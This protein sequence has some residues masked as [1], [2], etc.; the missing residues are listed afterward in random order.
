M[1]RAFKR[2]R[3]AARRRPLVLLLALV[4]L[5]LVPA[6]YMI[7]KAVRPAVEKQAAAAGK[8]IKAPW[9]QP[10][11][12]RAM[13]EASV[14]GP[15]APKALQQRLE[16]LAAHYGE[17]VGLAVADVERGWIAHVN[18]QTLLPQQSVSKTWVALATLDAVDRGRLRLDQPVV[19]GPADRSVFY[20]PIVG[21]LRK[22][23][24]RTTVGEL[25]QRAIE[26]SDN[27]AND[28]LIG[29]IGGAGE[30]GKTLA[31]KGLGGIRVG[32]AERDLQARIAGLT[33]SSDISGW[34]FK[35]ARALVP[36]EVRETAL[37]RYLADPDDGATPVGIVQG[38]MA[39]KRGELVSDDSTDLLLDLLA[40][41]KTGRRRL[42]AGLPGGWTIGDK[43]GTG[44]DWQG[45]SAGINDIG[46]ITAPDGRA[47]TVAVM[48]PN[49]KQPDSVRHRLF[50]EVAASVV[51]A[52][53]SER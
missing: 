5:P 9:P 18:G 3:R 51:Q 37:N 33:W 42:R 43:T 46:V 39:L 19:M 12:G 45:A 32:S 16:A 26:Q 20:E 13:A 31:A 15:P 38:L 40:N 21:R 49:T 14:P 44:P 27:A 47:Y 8:V 2:F 6:G 41:C 53:S 10:P 35:Q 29:L 25:L 50:R 48:I 17:P 52:W 1:S 4:L 36:D 7:G 22:D 30:V 24:Y 23:G 11:K 28:K 34:K